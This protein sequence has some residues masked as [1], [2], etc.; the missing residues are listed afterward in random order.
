M[1][2]EKPYSKKETKSVLKP[3]E[4]PPDSTLP[5]K[6]ALLRDYAKERTVYPAS[7]VP[8]PTQQAQGITKGTPVPPELTPEFVDN[9]T[10]DEQQHFLESIQVPE[11]QHGNLEKSKNHR[12]LEHYAQN[13]TEGGVEQ[14]AHID[15]GAVDKIR[16]LGWIESLKKGVN[17]IT[18][19]GKERYEQAEAKLQLTRLFTES[20]GIRGLDQYKSTGYTNVLRLLNAI[21][22]TPGATTRELTDTNQMDENVIRYIAS[23][24]ALPEN[25][26]I[27]ATGVGV[28]GDPKRYTLSE[29]GT[30]FAS[31]GNKILAAMGENT[32]LKSR[33]PEVDANNT[34][35]ETPTSFRF[36]LVKNVPEILKILQANQ[37]SQISSIDTQQSL[38]KTSALTNTQAALKFLFE[39]G[40]AS[41][42]DGNT[43]NIGRT[44]L[45][46]ISEKGIEFLDLLQQYDELKNSL[47]DL[48]AVEASNDRLAAMIN[49]IE[50]LHGQN[51]Q[52]S[53]QE[54][55][56][57]SSKYINQSVIPHLE[58]TRPP[59]IVSMVDPESTKGNYRKL[60]ILSE[61]ALNVIIP[62]IERYK[63]AETQ[64]IHNHMDTWKKAD[65]SPV[66]FY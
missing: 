22:Q 40:Y 15:S 14:P 1:S 39:Q 12:V 64:L 20:F 19:A 56:E 43:G 52:L 27:I 7:L 50:I 44:Y 10:A 5:Q 23:I 34:S 18:P 29:R 30:F 4:L 47:T 24:S 17:R 61:H 46:T 36:P 49:I 35:V 62:M 6:L 53:R 13:D 21:M 11:Y 37:H 42:I 2:L 65:G 58:Y 48:L 51:K 59:A 33:A 3:F 28:T 9:L 55:I 57:Q 66:K 32:Q 54:I 26:L 8:T 60:Y 25:Q 31:E 45:Y 41:R 63:I 38:E 16:R